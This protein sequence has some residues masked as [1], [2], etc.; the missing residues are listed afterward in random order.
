MQGGLGLAAHRLPELAEAVQ[1]ALGDEPARSGGSWPTSSPR[2]YCSGMRAVA[3]QHLHD[4]AEQPVLVG[5]GSG[6]L[7]LGHAVIRYEQSTRTGGRGA[8]DAPSVARSSSHWLVRSSWFS[9][10]S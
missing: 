3:Q 7:S 5:A 10:T 4:L 2:R 1:L 6:A 8:G 9:R